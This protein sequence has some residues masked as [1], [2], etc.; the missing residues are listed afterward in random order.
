MKTVA[1]FFLQAQGIPL[2]DDDVFQSPQIVLTEDSAVPISSCDVVDEAANQ[3]LDSSSKATDETDSQDEKPNRKISFA[4]LL[5]DKQCCDGL[6]W[7]S[8]LLPWNHVR[9]GQQAQLPFVK[10]IVFK[11]EQGVF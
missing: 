2:P 9:W 4:W 8:I 11:F 1:F 10:E 7:H 5:K 3:Q 6:K